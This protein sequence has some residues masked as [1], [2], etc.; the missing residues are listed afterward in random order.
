MGSLSSSYENIKESI[1]KS[2]LDF[3]DKLSGKVL[4]IIERNFPMI[5]FKKEDQV[6]FLIKDQGISIELGDI[7][8]AFGE[9]TVSIK[10]ELKVYRGN[11]QLF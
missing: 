2:N 11:K 10:Q 9:N 1:N 3:S 8:I 5:D 4:D 6:M 7:D